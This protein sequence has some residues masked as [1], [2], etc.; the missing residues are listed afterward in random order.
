[1]T[2][3]FLLNYKTG[4]V[5]SFSVNIF[6]FGARSFMKT[7]QFEDV[8]LIM[9]ISANSRSARADFIFIEHWSL[10]YPLVKTFVA[11]QFCEESP[12]ISAL[13]EVFDNDNR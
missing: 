3:V 7:P 1:M 12:N 10:Q 9:R 2:S 8:V 11:F 4:Q 6:W 5:V 13:E